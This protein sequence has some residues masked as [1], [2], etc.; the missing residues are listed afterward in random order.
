V[1]VAAEGFTLAFGGVGG[2]LMMAKKEI[3]SGRK[4]TRKSLFFYR[5][6]DKKGKV[7]IHDD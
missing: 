6:N 2:R 3:T 4:K 7:I 1:R 5:Y